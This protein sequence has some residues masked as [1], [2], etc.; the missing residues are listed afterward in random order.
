MI[1]IKIEIIS[2]LLTIIIIMVLIIK[3]LFCKTVLSINEL[4]VKLSKYLNTK[5][6]VTFY[7]T[8][9]IVLSLKDIITLMNI[10]KSYKKDYINLI[11][12]Y[13][14]IVNDYKKI[15]CKS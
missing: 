15:K 11:Q 2:L 8:L 10:N 12:E 6:K 3:M 9:N 4:I 14:K 1:K 7:L 13:N 5:D